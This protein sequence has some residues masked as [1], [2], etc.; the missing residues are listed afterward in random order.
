MNILKIITRSRKI[1]QKNFCDIKLSYQKQA[2]Y[3]FNDLLKTELHYQ[4]HFIKETNY[5]KEDDNIECHIDV[6]IYDK[7]D[8]K[9][10]QNNDLIQ[11]L[12]KQTIIEED[13]FVE[14]N[15]L[16]LKNPETYEVNNIFLL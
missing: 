3:R 8:D 16:K 12:V 2:F 7:N 1:Y 4:K 10:I 11:T 15:Y 9:K 5:Y 6:I 13:I 14:M